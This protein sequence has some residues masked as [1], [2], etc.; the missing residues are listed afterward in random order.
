MIG[1]VS[2]ESEEEGVV[3]VVGI[4]SVCKCIHDKVEVSNVSKASNEEEED[5]ETVVKEEF[6]MYSYVVISSSFT[7]IL[8]DTGVVVV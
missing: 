7:C 8:S 4:V 3:E 5:E 6:I 2:L 1:I